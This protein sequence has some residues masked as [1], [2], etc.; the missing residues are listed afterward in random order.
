MQKSN[1][2]KLKK[3][4]VFKRNLLCVLFVFFMSFTVFV[5]FADS[6]K[7]T[8]NF[9]KYQILFI[10]IGMKGRDLDRKPGNMAFYI[11]N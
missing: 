6:N 10:L 11:L 7:K 4:L 2:M 1:I 9:S 5:S 8:D 3:R